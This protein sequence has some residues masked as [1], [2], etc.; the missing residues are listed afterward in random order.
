LPWFVRNSIGLD[1]NPD[2]VNLNPDPECQTN[3]DQD[4]N[5]GQTLPL[6]KLDFDMKNILM[7]VICHKNIPTYV[8]TKAILK[9]LKSGLFFYFG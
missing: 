1:A 6:Q 9:G 2:P 3:A 5:H 8:G 7:W 4:P